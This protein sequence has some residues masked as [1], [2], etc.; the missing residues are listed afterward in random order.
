MWPLAICRDTNHAGTHSSS[1][2]PLMTGHPQ[3]CLACITGVQCAGQCMRSGHVVSAAR[4]VG[5]K[6]GRGQ[7][8]NVVP[9]GE[10]LQR[11]ERLI[12]SCAEIGAGQA[13]GH[14]SMGTR[15]YRGKRLSNRAYLLGM[16]HVC[17]HSFIWGGG[18]GCVSSTGPAAP[19]LLLRVAAGRWLA[20]EAPVHAE[21]LCLRS[22][23]AVQCWAGAAAL[24]PPSPGRRAAARRPAPPAPAAA[25]SELQASGLP[26]S[27]PL[28]GWWC[29]AA[30]RADAPPLSCRGQG[31]RSGEGGWVWGGKGRGR[32]GVWLG[33]TAVA[34][35]L[36]QRGNAAWQA[37]H[38]AATYTYPKQHTEHGRQL[39]GHRWRRP[40]RR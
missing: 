14:N 33:S 17:R 8:L 5:M 25:A 22:A 34:C 26:H 1:G 6:K 39:T 36:S 37:P 40:M 16:A 11:K 38:S 12:A 2:H 21:R 32:H 28:A 27:Q 18:K 31:R 13:Q 29:G 23:G 3:I 24:T 4:A 7:V 30:W 35:P 9:R 10:R 20:R 15:G 19:A